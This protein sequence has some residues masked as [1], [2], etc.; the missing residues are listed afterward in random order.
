[1]AP[2]HRQR[3]GPNISVLTPLMRMPDHHEQTLQVGQ[4]AGAVF[5]CLRAGLHERRPQQQVFGGIAAQA[6]FG[7]QHQART[8][9]VGTPRA[10]DDAAAVP[11]QIAHRGVDLRQ[12]HFH[13]GFS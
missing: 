7:R 13:R 2:L 9:L 8:L 5:Q 11:G 1:M 3:L 4:F 6:E 12:G 10:V